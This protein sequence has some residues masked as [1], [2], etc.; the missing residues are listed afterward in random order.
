MRMGG[1]I[2]R[3]LCPSTRLPHPSHWFS[4]VS[5][6]PQVPELRRELRFLEGSDHNSLKW[7]PSLLPT[8]IPLFVVNQ[9]AK[10]S[11]VKKCTFC[12]LQLTEAE[13]LSQ[14]QRLRSAC[15]SGTSDFSHLICF[16]PRQLGWSTG[17]PNWDIIFPTFLAFS[18]A[19]APLFIKVLNAPGAHCQLGSD[20]SG[21]LVSGVEFLW[22]WKIPC[23]NPEQAGCYEE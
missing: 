15:I 13:R 17:P 4:D 3:V 1:E 14:Q 16:Y 23:N 8:S 5:Y 20:F 9:L 6:Y 12:C 18:S 19:C 11:E 2:S 22:V 7:K 21:L 10:S